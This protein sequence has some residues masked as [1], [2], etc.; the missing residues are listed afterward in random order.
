MVFTSLN[1]VPPGN[2]DLGG[3]CHDLRCAQF[4]VSTPAGLRCMCGEGSEL[5]ADGRSCAPQAN[6]TDPLACSE[7]QFQCTGSRECLAQL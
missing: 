5:G 3:G 7:S 1:R 2:S 4:C 6:Y